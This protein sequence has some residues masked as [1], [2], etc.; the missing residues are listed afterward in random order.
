MSMKRSPFDPV[1]DPC[2]CWPLLQA[3]GMTLSLC[4]CILPSSATLPDCFESQ[5]GPRQRPDEK[6]SPGSSP[7]SESVR[8]LALEGRLR[9]TAGKHDIENHLGCNVHCNVLHRMNS[10]VA[11]R[12]PLRTTFQL[13]RPFAGHS[14]L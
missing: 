4:L 8:C 11:S 1:G 12:L 14:L 7:E 13:L 5:G 10:R 2:A 9:S 3:T 6:I